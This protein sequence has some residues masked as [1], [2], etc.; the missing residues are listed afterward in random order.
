MYQV[1]ETTNKIEFEESK[2]YGM[3]VSEHIKDW[4]DEDNYN[5]TRTMPLYDVDIEEPSRWQPTPP[6]YMSGIEPHWNKIRPMV[7]SSSSQFKP[8]KHPKFSL[9]VNSDFY[10]ELK[11]VYDVSNRIVLKGDESEEIKIARFWDCNP[12]VSVQKGHLMVA[13][14]KITPGGHW[15]GITKIACKQ[16]DYNFKETIHANTITAIAIFDA[17]I[18]CWNEKYSSNLI[19]PETLINKY[20]DNHWKPVLQTPPFPEYTSGHSVVSGAASVVLTT[21]F[22]EDF[23][24]NDDTELS[25]GLPIRSFESFSKAA[26]EAA[27]SRLYGGIHYRAAIDNG[28]TQGK[29]LGDFIVQKLDMK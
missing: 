16:V 28:L 25:F 29:Q 9:E 3:E 14:K 10:R 27:V 26:E 11:E 24:F 13:A 21:I 18:S 4:M 15:M 6:A 20:I 5:E 23:A 2:T 1:W 19:R 8:L 17:F 7:L 22:G 12:Y